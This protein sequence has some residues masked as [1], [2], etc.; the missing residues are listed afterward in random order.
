MP[1]LAARHGNIKGHHGLTNIAFFDGHV[2]ALDTKGITTFVDPATGQ[3]GGGED[4]VRP[5][6]EADLVRPDVAAAAGDLDPVR[7]VGR[8]HPPRR[9]K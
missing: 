5:V 9:P 4:L 3:G 2:A 8:G 1:A 6:A 7:P